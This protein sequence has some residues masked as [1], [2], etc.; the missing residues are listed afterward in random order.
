[1]QEIN[2]QSHA[3]SVALSGIVLNID[4]AAFYGTEAVASMEVFG[5][6]QTLA[7]QRHEGIGLPFVKINNR[8]FYKGEALL[9]RL[10]AGAVQTA[11]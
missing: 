1:M 2:S 3:V 5:A 10:N 9:D 7:R 4:P 8:V 6:K 11:A